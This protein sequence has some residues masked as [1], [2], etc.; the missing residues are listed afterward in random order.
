MIVELGHYCLVLAL[1]LV[2]QFLRVLLTRHPGVET[3][4]LRDGDD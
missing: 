2:D 3:P 4:R 1:A